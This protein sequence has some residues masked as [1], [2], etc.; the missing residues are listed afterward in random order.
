MD[1]RLQLRPSGPQKPRKHRK[2]KRRPEFPQ[3]HF[4]I[5]QTRENLHAS[6][7]R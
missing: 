4:N 2:Q 1:I 3:P 5:P 6:E 7:Q